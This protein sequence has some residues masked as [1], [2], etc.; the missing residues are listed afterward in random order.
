MKFARVIPS[1]RHPVQSV[2]SVQEQWLS[3]QVRDLVE[4][5]ARLREENM[6]LRV[7]YEP[8]DLAGRLPPWQETEGAPF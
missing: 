5:N 2:Q 8:R 7:K 3:E 4:V 6:R 1:V